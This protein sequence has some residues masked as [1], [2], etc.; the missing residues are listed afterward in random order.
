LR[1]ET[2][3]VNETRGNRKKEGYGMNRRNYGKKNKEVGR[4]KIQ[5]R[6]G[7]K[8]MKGS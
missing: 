7:R 3:G 5:K 2:N 4:R 6:D 8:A 1:E